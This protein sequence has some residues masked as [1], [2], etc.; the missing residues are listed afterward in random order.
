L[1]ECIGRSVVAGWIADIEAGD[2]LAFE[3]AQRAVAANP[4]DGEALATAAWAYATLGGRF[5]A[6]LDHADRAL[7]IHA[8]SLTVRNF[9]GAVF[10]ASG[11]SA[12]AI[13]QYEA[14]ARLSPVD[15]RAYVHLS[16]IATAQFFARNF[17]EAVRGTGRV[18]ADWPK[19]A[20]SM[21]Y[22]AASLAHLGRTAEANEVVSQLLQVQPNSTLTRSRHSRFRF[23]WMYDLYL[24]GL[25]A[26]GLPP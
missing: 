9:C 26:A 19:N 24:G 21:R 8:N 13:E 11:E 25:E 5:D 14:A 10:A 17:E 2:E 16:G 20:V 3:Y 4:E 7:R 15:P 22:R 6:A 1:A 18:L 12:R 23:P